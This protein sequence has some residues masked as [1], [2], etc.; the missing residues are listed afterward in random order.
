M[1]R[2]K[3]ARYGQWTYRGAWAIEI[4]AAIL[5]L[6]TGI[7]LGWQ[8]YVANESATAFDFILQSAPFFM[9][10]LA[11]LT[12]I[13]IA[14]LLFS[15]PHMYKPVL[16]VFLL[17][18]AFITFETVFTG[19]ERAF[20]LRQLEYEQLFADL[21]QKKRELAIL[22]GEVGKLSTTDEVSRAQRQ[23][24]ELAE[25]RASARK[26][27]IEEIDRINKRQTIPPG[28]SAELERVDKQKKEAEEDLERLYQRRDKELE[29]A[30][31]AFERQRDS[32]VKRIES[33]QASGDT[34]YANKQKQELARLKN[35]A[36]AIR[37]QY[38]PGIEKKSAEIAVLEQTRERLR[39]RIPTSDDPQIK[40]RRAELEEQ[41]RREDAEWQKRE[42]DAR[43]NLELAQRSEAERSASLSEKQKSLEE[44]NAEII[45][46]DR[47]R[48][49]KART[50][51]V[52]RIASRFFG[53]KPEDVSTDQADLVAVIWFGSLALLAALTGP[54]TAM[55]ALGLQRIA[56]QP[57]ERRGGKLANSLRR[58]IVNWRSKRKRQVKVEVP[59][60]K[61]VKEI[62]YVPILTD[63]PEAIRKTLHDKV[64]KE[65]ADLVMVNIAAKDEQ[66]GVDGQPRPSPA[67]KPKCAPKDPSPKEAASPRRK[68]PRAGS[69]KA[70]ASSEAKKP[71][72]RRRS[73]KASE[74]DGRDKT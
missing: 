40:Q 45:E 65:V 70:A 11:E 6:T 61:V 35:P 63:D 47:Q 39:A 50:D 66:Q 25:R 44:I 27:V 38:E 72:T 20:A 58:F 7:A 4:V 64:P 23:I 32:F 54:L 24:E 51:Q 36:P 19:L 41:L 8:A 57:P 37:A 73:R 1:M 69:A 21:N 49:P 17:G 13:P 67:A 31:A 74:P 18:L 5:G 55:V 2:D 15:A 26:N 14:T 60:E 62:L 46:L 16:A 42:D 12:K 34:D 9:V 56:E 33:A 68:T 71:S 30:Q 22:E 52:R 53:E 29:R 3:L 48:V 59:V 28:L 43:D 10:A